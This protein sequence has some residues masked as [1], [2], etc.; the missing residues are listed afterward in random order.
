MLRVQKWEGRGDSFEVFL[1]LQ[2]DGSI[3]LEIVREG[4]TLFASPFPL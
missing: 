2:L 4:V 1:G 3:F